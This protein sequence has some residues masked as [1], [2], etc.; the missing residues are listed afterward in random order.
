LLSRETGVLAAMRF[1]PVAALIASILVLA[2]HALAVESP[3]T[4]DSAEAASVEK[5][6]SYANG[7]DQ[8]K[9]DLYLPRQKNFPTV[10][11]VYGGGGHS[12]SR[13]GVAAVGKKLQSL[14]YGCALLSHRLAPKDKFPAQIEDVAA[15]FAWVKK[16]IAEK[17]G[18]PKR[19][20]IMGHSSGA[21]LSAL[22][23]CDPRYLAE[24]GLSPTDIAGVVA[25][26]AIVDLEPK[27]DGKGFGNSLVANPR[28]DVFAKDADSLRNASPIQHVRKGMPPVLLVV[29]ERD[30][31]MLEADGRA[32][33]EK[34]KAA[35]GS[36]RIFV[37]KGRDHMGVVQALL[38]DKDPLVEQ[39]TAFLGAPN[40]GK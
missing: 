38:K 5:D 40:T 20:F 34:A 1:A 21:H 31:P 3:P 12:G 24:H 4:S 29:G 16:H 30:F 39:V 19:T 23:A 26:S 32:F 17:G 22:L 25:L 37:A 9:L 13:K 15:G 6:I 18:D 10:V 28:M 33:V 11:F 8:Q 2:E 36:A 14:G 35:G 27:K 7:G